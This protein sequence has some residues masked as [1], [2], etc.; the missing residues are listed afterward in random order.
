MRSVQTLKIAVAVVGLGV[1]FLGVRL[2]N[3]VLRWTG[4]G[5]VATAVLLRFVRPRQ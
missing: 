4:I 3:E 1:F 2:G 5:L